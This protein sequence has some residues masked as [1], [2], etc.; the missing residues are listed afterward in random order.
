MTDAA[1]GF[2]AHTGWAAAVAIGGPP[3]SPNVLNRR[4]IDLRG[5]TIPFEAYHAAGRLDLTLAEDLIRRAEEVAIGLA[6]RAIREIFGELR[7]SG[8]GAVV[9]GIIVGYGR[10]EPPLE[11]I[12]ASHTAKHAAE[13]EVYRHALIQASQQCGL[14][15]TGAPERNLYAQAAAALRLSSDE[16]RRRLTDVGRAFGP[17]WTQDQKSATL[18]AWLA[19]TSATRK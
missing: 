12:L 1:L 5:E 16:L 19:L 13:G 8:H 11:K 6:T 4:R 10:P 14:R 2:R 7:A 15:V 17:P 18:V 3:S 9:A